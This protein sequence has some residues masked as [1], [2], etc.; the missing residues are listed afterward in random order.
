MSVFTVFFCGTGSNSFDIHNKYYP[1]GEVISSLASHHKGSEFIDW[2][3]C[4]GP[5][6]GN[7]QEDHKWVT[8][9]NYSQ[10]NGILTGAGWDENVAHALAVLKCELEWKRTQLT[11]QEYEQLKAAKVPIDDAKP[12]GCWY[13]R[14][15]EYPERKITPQDLQLQKARIMRKG[16]LPSRVNIIGWS[17]GGV[18]C[19]MLANAMARDSALASIPVNIFAIDPVPGMG[20]FYKDKC[21]LQ[22]NVKHYVGVYARD[23]RT[24]GFS[25]IVPKLASSTTALILPFPG[26]H[27]TLAGNGAIDGS[28]GAQALPEPGALIRHMAELYLND[29]GT[30]FS[31]RHSLTF[32]DIAKLYKAIAADQDKYLALRTKVYFGSPDAIGEERHIGIGESGRSAAFSEAKGR[33]YEAHKGLSMTDAEV[34]A[35]LTRK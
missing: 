3:I 2:L 1:K 26:R 10:L 28:E 24:K 22:S 32:K 29:W 20:N 25:P 35:F 7:L 16:K 27:A 31:K 4:D 21:S 15:F 9:G 30:Q 33:E 8:P 13:W 6:S 11:P 14:T 17:R 34:L 19:H 18:S 5:G 12:G 23:E